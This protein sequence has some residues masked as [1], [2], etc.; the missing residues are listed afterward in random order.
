MLPDCPDRLLSD[1]LHLCCRLSI[2]MSSIPERNEIETEYTWD[3]SGIY[4]DA[5]EWESAYES[6]QDQLTDLKDM[7]DM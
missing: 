4:T 3:L 1:K 7:K 2:Y 5:A 6:V